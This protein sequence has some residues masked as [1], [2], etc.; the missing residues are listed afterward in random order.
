MPINP[1]DVTTFLTQISNL[2]R[3]PHPRWAFAPH[4]P[5]LVLTIVDAIEIGL[6]TDNRFRITPELIVLF[7]TNWRKLVI[8]DTWTESIGLP[9]RHLIFDKFWGLYA[10]GEQMSS[11]RLGETTSLKFLTGMV[12][13]G[14][15]TDVVWRLLQAGDVR[16]LVKEQIIETYFPYRTYTLATDD[17][18]RSIADQLDREAQQLIDEAD[19][20]FRVKKRVYPEA[21]EGAFVRHRL[22]PKV[23]KKL[24][25]DSCAVCR[26]DARIA[27]AGSVVDAAHIVPFGV[28]HN[29]DPRNGMALCKNHHW[30][31]DKGWFGLDD[32]Y[33]IVV[34]AYFGEQHQFITSGAS[35]L[36]PVDVRLAPA[37]PALRWHRKNRL[38]GFG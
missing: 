23:I 22:F 25:A 27:Q 4:K 9:F 3:A 35:L 18:A 6:V 37:K 31:F 36:L 5:V 14:R 32:D 11:A 38:I 34:S 7:R 10:G 24:Y 20:V 30:G 29:D 26:L 12:D 13:E 1:D 19:S 2:H 16:R 28:G 15:L 8:P 33:R 21:D 17:L